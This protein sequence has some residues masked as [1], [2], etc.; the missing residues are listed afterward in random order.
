MAA[1]EEFLD[2][3]AGLLGLL[4]RFLA[5]SLDAGGEC[6]DEEGLRFPEELPHLPHRLLDVELLLL[7]RALGQNRGGEEQKGQRC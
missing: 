2:G 5:V 6:L 4:G 3:F 7:P 1:T